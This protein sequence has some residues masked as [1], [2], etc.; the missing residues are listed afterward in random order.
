[1]GAWASFT[2]AAIGLAKGYWRDEEKTRAVSSLTP[3]LES[4]CTGLEI[5]V[6]IS[7]TVTSSFWEGRIPSQNQGTSY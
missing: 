4:V 1:M 6:V 5:W 3:R 7:P 2:L